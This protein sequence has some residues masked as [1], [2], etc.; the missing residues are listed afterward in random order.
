MAQPTNPTPPVSKWLE[1][2]AD[3]G[4]RLT[5]PRRAVVEIIAAS[6]HVLTP[7]EVFEQARARYPK[8]GLVTVYRTVEKLEELDLIQRVHQPSGC[9]A[10]ITAFSGHEHLLICDDCGRVEFFEGDDIAPLMDKVGEKSGFQVHGHWLQLFGLC[11]D[12]RNN[13]RTTAS[14]A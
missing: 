13:H 9:Q 3:N 10:F 8:L 12:C 7:Y 6:R 1:C 11:Q 5:A 14:S 4:Y 2:L